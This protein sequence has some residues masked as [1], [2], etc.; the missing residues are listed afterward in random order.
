[1]INED[2]QWQLDQTNNQIMRGLPCLIERVSPSVVYV[3]AIADNYNDNYE[4]GYDWSG[5]GVII[6]SHIVL[7]ARHIIEDANSLTITVVDGNTY[8]AVRWEVDPNNDCGLLF[9]EEDLGPVI[10]FADSDKIEIGDRVIIIGSPY[11]KEFLNT[12][13]NGIVSGLDREILFFGEDPMIT[14]D[15]ASWPGN[16]G[17]PVFDIQGRVIGILVGGTWNGDNFSIVVPIN[18]CKEFYETSKEVKP[19]RN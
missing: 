16:S 6:G 10:K 13:T 4:Y 19:Q 15:A 17:G 8:E 14:A 18:I 7:T 5:S 3:E 1:V 9:F 12:A 11:G 2:L